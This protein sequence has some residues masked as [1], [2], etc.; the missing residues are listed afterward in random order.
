MSR[1]GL[2]HAQHN[3]SHLHALVPASAHA[4]WQEGRT[5]A[6][7]ILQGLP[8]QSERVRSLGGGVKKR[9]GCC[10]RAVNATSVVVGR[11]MLVVVCAESAVLSALYL[12]FECW[13]SASGA[14]VAV[15]LQLFPL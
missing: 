11:G 5:R 10:T 13:L 15:T 4:A 1:V 2:Q 8:P 9:Q 14:C 12:L 7:S 6:A 3:A